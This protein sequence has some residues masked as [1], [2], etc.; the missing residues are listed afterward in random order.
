MRKKN[1][2]SCRLALGVSVVIGWK[3]AGNSI[4]DDGW[5]CRDHNPCGGWKEDKESAWHKGGVSSDALI[6]GFEKIA[7]DS[8]ASQEEKP[9]K[10]ETVATGSDAVQKDAYPAFEKSKTAGGVRITVSAPEGV[11]PRG[12]ALWVKQMK[13]KETIEKIQTAVQEDME[14]EDRDEMIRDLLA[15]DITIQNDLGQ[16]LQPNLQAGEVKVSFSLMDKKMEEDVQL[17]YFT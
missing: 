8:D 12:A 11:F 15:F 4:C 17:E 13:E 7:T 5:T 3:Y 9:P 1:R 16:E 2:W 6:S 14:R 10:F